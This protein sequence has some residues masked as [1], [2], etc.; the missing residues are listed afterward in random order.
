M[1]RMT[2]LAF[3]K[4]LSR[5]VALVLDNSAPMQ[6]RLTDGHTR[7]EDATAR[8]TKAL[9][10]VASGSTV[11][12]YETAPTA[13]QVSVFGSPGAASSALSRIRLVD[14][15]SA[16]PIATAL[17]NRGLSGNA[18]NTS[19]KRTVLCYPNLK[20][21]DLGI[22]PTGITFNASGAAVQNLELMLGLSR[23]REAS[24]HAEMRQT[25]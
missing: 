10:D 4:T 23:S 19:S 21:Q 17:S 3:W 24:A 13:H 11:T 20:F 2:K 9:S 5:A 14:A 7:F 15:P 18:F 1:P 12:V 22:V 16:T 6:A 8:A 25:A